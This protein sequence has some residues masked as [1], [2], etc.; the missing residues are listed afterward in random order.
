MFAIHAVFQKLDHNSTPLTNW[1]AALNYWMYCYPAVSLHLLAKANKIGQS[2]FLLGR[3][4]TRDHLR[5]VSL[6]QDHLIEKP[7]G[8]W[9]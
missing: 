3:E 1:A 6:G 2:L 8:R 4:L 7:A 9:D 5:E